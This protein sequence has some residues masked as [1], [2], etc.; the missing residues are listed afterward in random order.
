[1]Q[2]IPFDTL[3]KAW[4]AQPS[5]DIVAVGVGLLRHRTQQL[6]NVHRAGLVQ[7]EVRKWLC[8]L[9]PAG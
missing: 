6:I 5:S 4:H 8:V 3:V 9:C 2:T 1:L 7:A